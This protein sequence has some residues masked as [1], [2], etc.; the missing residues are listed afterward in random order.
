MKM[1]LVELA[2]VLVLATFAG[3]AA[4]AFSADFPERPVRIIT[5]FGGGGEAAVRLIAEKMAKNLGQA[6]LVDPQPAA[7]GVVAANAVKRAAPDGYTI[8]A[9]TG[10]A[11]VVRPLLS[12]ATIYDPIKDFEPISGL[13]EPTILIAVRSSLPITTLQQLIE[14]AKKA[15]GR[16]TMGAAG[17]LNINHLSV[18]RLQQIAGVEFNFIPYTNDAQA[19]T[20]LMAGRIDAMV[21]VAATVG[22]GEERYRTIAAFNASR[23]PGYQEIPTV[24]EQLPAFKALPSWNGFFAPAGTPPHIVARLNKAITSALAEADI[25]ERLLFNGS[26]PVPSSPSE[27]GANLRAALVDVG[28]LIRDMNL[29]KQ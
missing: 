23:R 12:E 17:T 13:T 26:I 21:A 6:V 8:L 24:T 1:R 27:T 9:G 16:M 22:K 10:N 4:P 14:Y 20:E 7:A 3:I 2:K 15:P 29:Q 11:L 28:G 5:A 18:L 25:K 19:K